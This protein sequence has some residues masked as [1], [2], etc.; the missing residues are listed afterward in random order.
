MTFSCVTGLF[1]GCGSTSINK[2]ERMDRNCSRL[3]VAVV[4]DLAIT[5]FV[6]SLAI[7]A[8]IGKTHLG[9][10]PLNK[11]GPKLATGL[12]GVSAASLVLITGLM[13]M[14]S[15]KARTKGDDRP[16]NQA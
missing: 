14:L 10:I 6:L 7:Y 1:D 5:A 15:T 3:T 8:L 16:V 9:A 13:V 12:L 2:S 11:V 4:A